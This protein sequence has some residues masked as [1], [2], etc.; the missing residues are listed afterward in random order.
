MWTRP[1]TGSAVV[2][3]V[4]P[5]WSAAK[6]I[7]ESIAWM[8]TAYIKPSAVEVCA[9]IERHRYT[10]NYSGPLR[11]TAQIRGDDP[12]QLPAVVLVNVC[13]RLYGEVEESAPQ[14]GSTNHRH[15]LQ[16][17]FHRR[18]NNGQSFRSVCLG[19][20]EF[21]AHYVGPFRSETRVQETLNLTI[22]VMLHSVFDKPARGRAAPRFVRDQQVMNGRL[23]YAK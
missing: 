5:P 19:W 10:N 9:P 2:S 12:F 3:E 20:S 6:G 8:R 13:Y 7:F 18:L 17:M 11:K 15:A 16:E 22:P 14:T 4:V 1:D 21:I 23:E